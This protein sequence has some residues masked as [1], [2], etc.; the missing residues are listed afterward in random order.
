MPPIGRV[1]S[2]PSSTSRM[3]RFCKDRLTA[4]STAS[5]AR[6]RNLCRFSR[7]LPRGLSRRSM[8]CMF[9]PTWVLAPTA[10]LTRLLDA[11]VPF[12]QPANLPFRVAPRHHARDEFAMLLFGLTIL[13]RSERDDRQQI[14]DLREHTLLDDF[15]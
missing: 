4:C 5:L 3:E 6:R 14:L 10:Y 13:L 15:P 9:A 8:M 7:L 12:H 2:P 11:H 1:T